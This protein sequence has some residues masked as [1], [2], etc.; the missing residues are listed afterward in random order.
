MSGVKIGIGFGLW[1]LGMPSP[2]T[3]C[4]YAERAEEVGIDSIWLSDHIVSRQP[5]LDISCI[6]AMFAARTKKIKMGPSVL[7][8]PARD[9]IQ[10]AKT[11]ATLDYL[12]G[13]R[14]RVIMAVGLGSDPRDCIA[15]GINP[16]ERAKRM[17]EGVQV[18][19]KLWAGENVSHEGKFYKF[20]DVT[21]TPRPVKGSLDVWIGGKS[22][23]AIKRTARYGDGWFPSFVTP[24]EF[25][26]G[27]AKMAEYGKQYGRTV[28][29]REA[30]VL[31][32]THIN[33]N[34]ARAQE[35]V[36]KFFSGFP[37]AAESM[38]AR[39][40]IGSAQEC[41]EKVQSYVEAGCSKFVLWPI[42]PPDELV[43][44]IE[45]YGKEIIP[46]F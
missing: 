36:Q 27:L 11:Y 39:C 8:L 2:E 6:M 10:V 16:D 28:N 33:D 35:A 13:S 9:P 12:T 4:S 30:G 18:M 17:E 32:F 37:V 22:D 43:P 25:K 19:R 20:T 41:I 15:C 29:P 40:A 34:R 5:D 3:I 45:R 23:L 31:I 42:V 1:R 26:D 21:I 38:P 24:D 46:R 14:G 44:Q 7:T